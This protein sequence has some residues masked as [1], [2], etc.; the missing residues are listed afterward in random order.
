MVVSSDLS[1]AMELVLDQPLA[2][3]SDREE[4]L[5]GAVWLGR[6][7]PHCG[8]GGARVGLTS[9]QLLFVGARERH[10]HMREREMQQR[11]GSEVKNSNGVTRSFDDD[12]DLRQQRRRVSHIYL[13]RI[14][15]R[16]TIDRSVR[17]KVTKCW[18]QWIR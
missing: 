2:R 6:P 7:A 18:Q 8:I 13:A 11:E 4:Q 1:Y 3:G 10:G 12:D 5:E 9:E 14:D 17:G 16:H 15:I